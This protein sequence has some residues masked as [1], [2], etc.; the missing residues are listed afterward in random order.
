MT[1]IYYC[2]SL[3]VSKRRCKIKEN[4]EEGKLGGE[5]CLTDSEPRI[6]HVVALLPN[7]GR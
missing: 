6:L 1:I 3:L 5:K 2:P 7:A 4:K